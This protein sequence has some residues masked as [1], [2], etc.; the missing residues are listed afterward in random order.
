ME[1]TAYIL[2]VLFD[3]FYPARIRIEDGIFKEVAPILITEDTELDVDGLVVPGLID[4]H[5]QLLHNSQR[6]RCATV[7]LLLSAILMKLQTSWGLRA[8]K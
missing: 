8:L 7:P 4:A 2:D 5:I 1:F 3:S 6:L